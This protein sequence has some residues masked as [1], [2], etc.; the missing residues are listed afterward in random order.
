LLLIRRGLQRSART[1]ESETD[2]EERRSQVNRSG[3]QRWQQMEQQQQ[4]NPAASSAEER[5]RDRETALQ[6]EFYVPVERVREAMVHR[7]LSSW[8]DRPTRCTIR[9]PEPQRRRL[10]PPLINN[11]R[12]RWATAAPTSGPFGVT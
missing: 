2:E 9:T 7:F 10:I 4:Q 5:K 8:R 1:V 6:A 12:A 11:I 3:Q